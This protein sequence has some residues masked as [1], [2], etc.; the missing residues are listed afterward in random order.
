MPVVVESDISAHKPVVDCHQIHTREEL[1]YGMDL[2]F[3]CLEQGK[4][5]SAMQI[6]QHFGMATPELATLPTHTTLEPA[7]VT[8]INRPTQSA[9]LPPHT[10]LELALVTPI[11]AFCSP[12]SWMSF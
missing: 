9:I 5:K 3:K 11:C 7:L 12:T 1:L 10:T 2:V 4:V 8:P 6:L